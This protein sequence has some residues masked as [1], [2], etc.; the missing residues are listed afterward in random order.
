M[1]EDAV[2][3]TRSTLRRCTMRVNVA[4]TLSALHARRAANTPVRRDVYYDA[5]NRHHKRFIINMAT[6]TALPAARDVALR[7]LR[8]RTRTLV[9]TL[10]SCLNSHLVLAGTRSCQRYCIA[11]Y[12]IRA[13][14]RK[15]QTLRTSWHIIFLALLRLRWATVEGGAIANGAGRLAAL[16]SNHICSR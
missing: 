10:L 11:R 6:S 9:A 12:L 3:A 1:V 15:Q 5:L 4:G 8:R 13:A 14:L 16:S 7:T 2:I